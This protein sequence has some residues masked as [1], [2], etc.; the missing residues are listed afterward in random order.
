MKI[1]LQITFSEDVGFAMTPQKHEPA[2]GV[3]G[4]PQSHSLSLQ[5]AARSVACCV[6][7]A[8]SDSF[9]ISF[10]RRVCDFALV[11]CTHDSGGSTGHDQLPSASSVHEIEASVVVEDSKLGRVGIKRP[12]LAKTVMPGKSLMVSCS[13]KPYS[14]SYYYCYSCYYCWHSY[15]CS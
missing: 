2:R 5:A 13:G 12:R 7:Q 10:E 15:C 3:V 14:S 9:S 6:G 1:D 4:V 8:W 11:T